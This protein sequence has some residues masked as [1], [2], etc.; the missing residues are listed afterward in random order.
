M[1]MEGGLS[2]RL[3][4]SLAAGWYRPA[5]NKSTLASLYALATMPPLLFFLRCGGLLHTVLGTT[6]AP[7]P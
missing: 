6:T 1:K 5:T 4:G 3:F 7:F 2:A